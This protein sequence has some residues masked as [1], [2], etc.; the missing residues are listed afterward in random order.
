MVGR[1][2]RRLLDEQEKGESRQE[3]D[4]THVEVAQ[5]VAKHQV[6]NVMWDLGVYRR[7][8]G[9]HR[10]EVQGQKDTRYRRH[11]LQEDGVGRAIDGSRERVAEPRVR[12]P[13]IGEQGRPRCL[14]EVNGDH[15]QG[16][17]HDR[18]RAL[19]Q[20]VPPRDEVRIRLGREVTRPEEPSGCTKPPSV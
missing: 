2:P 18:Q 14:H 4:D 8:D 6:A 13:E 1:A 11:A 15:G 7:G 12:K 16:G 9:A 3:R 19:A 10:G 17:K 20:Q 5:L